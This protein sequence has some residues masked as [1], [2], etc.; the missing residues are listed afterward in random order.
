MGLRD[1][2]S[3]HWPAR[4]CPALIR[5]EPAKD[6]LVNVQKSGGCDAMEGA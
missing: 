1:A 5:H 3:G 6:R 4:P 2:L